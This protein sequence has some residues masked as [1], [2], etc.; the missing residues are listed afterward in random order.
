MFVS[1]KNLSLI[2]LVSRKMSACSY[3]LQP[4]HERI[5]LPGVPSLC[6]K[7]QKPFPESRVQRSA[8]TSRHNA[9]LFDQVLI[10]TESDVLH[11]ELVYTKI[12]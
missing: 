12:V 6:G 11:T 7:L 8:L 2:H 4:F 10:R 1:K 5:H 3:M 9:R